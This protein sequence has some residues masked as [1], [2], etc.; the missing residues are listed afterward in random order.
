MQEIVA[1][2]RAPDGCPWDREQTLLTLRE[3]LLNEC[4]EVLEALDVEEGGV[5]N[6]E[7]IIEELGDMF[8]VPTMMV[9]IAC[10][11]GRFQ[12]ADV[13]RGIVTK[14]I[15]RHPH[16]FSTVDV[17]NVDEVLTNWDAIKAKEKADR[18]EIARDP[19]DGVPEALPALEKA[20]KFQSKAVKAGL[21]DQELLAS[22]VTDALAQF[23]SA[24]NQTSLGELLWALTALSRRHGLNPEDALRS[25][26]VNFRQRNG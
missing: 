10:E 6:R 23:E 16:V 7:S 25:Y 9:Q 5:N 2:L 19:L 1:H 14:L 11:E 21:V 22:T 26:V 15:R 4:H 20:R 8:L 18:G 17:E 12:M 13:M 24:P 3:G